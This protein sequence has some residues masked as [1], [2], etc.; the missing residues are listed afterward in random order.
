MASKRLSANSSIQKSPSFVLCHSIDGQAIQP[1][2]ALT[3]EE[4]VDTFVKTYLVEPT[5]KVLFYD[6]IFW[7]D[8]NNGHNLPL[9]VAILVFGAV[10]FTF[11]LKFINI[12]GFKHAIDLVRGKYDDPHSEGEVS[13]FQALTAALSAT[14]GLGNIA[15][16]AIAISLGG[17]GATF[18]MIAC[19]VLGM[20]SKFTEVTLGQKYRTIRPNGQLMGGGMYYLS[21]GLAE[22]GLPK[23]GKVMSV[24]FCVLCI[25]G[26]LAAGG[27]FQT[28]QSGALVSARY[29]FFAGSGIPFGLIMTTAIGIVIVGG[30]KRIAEVA[31]K[32]VPLMCGIYVLLCLWI[33]IGHVTEIPGAFGIIIEGAFAPKAAFG[34]IVGVLIMGFKRA[35]FSNEAGVGSAP[36]AHAAAKVNHPVEEGYV[37][38]LEPFIDTVVVCTMTALVIIVTGA[39]DASN[40]TFTDLIQSKEGAA[41]TAKA[42]EVEVSFFPHVLTLASVLFA[43]STAISWSYYGERCWTYLFGEKTSLLYKGMFLTSVFVGAVASS[44]SILDFGDILL[45]GMAVPNIPGL[46]LLGPIVKK[47]IADYRSRYKERFNS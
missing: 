23:L 2:S 16:V 15:G 25:G 46:I 18:W 8:K 17:P 33:L 24:V 4:N 10:F 42:M 37:A 9:A 36:I 39:W 26:A 6:V 30:I 21:K 29:S 14:V 35:S 5:G 44:K 47:E 38:L 12:R 34:G 43:F 11:Y 7:D 20:S 28:N 32:V 19:G 45:L 1:S 3:F 40:P 31:E 22:R 41:L 27:A 13:H